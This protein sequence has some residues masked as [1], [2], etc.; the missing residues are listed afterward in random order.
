MSLG[1]Q[2][3]RSVAGAPPVLNHEVPP[4]AGAELIDGSLV[5][6]R[7]TLSAASE[8]VR[9]AESR[10]KPASLAGSVNR[11]LKTTPRAVDG[12]MFW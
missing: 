11:S 6:T 3:R 10:T 2:V 9:R 5:V 4:G 8:P 7:Q 12:P 1:V